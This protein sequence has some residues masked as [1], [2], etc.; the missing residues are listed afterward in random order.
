MTWLL[1]GKPL[2]SVLVSRQRY[3]GD[4]VMAT[5]V[6]EALR[7]GD[8][9]L[10]LGFLCETG[11]GAV[12]AG[13]DLLDD[14]HLLGRKR[15]GADARARGMVE[16]LSLAR[17]NDVESPRIH[18]ASGT[19]DLIKQLKTA[20]YDL[21]VDLFFN[22]FSAWLFKLAGIPF[23][24]GGTPKWRRRL[25]TH[26]VVRTDA[27]WSHPGLS[28][29]APG[30]LGEHLCRL[31][32]LVHAET[33]LPFLDWL[34]KELS[35]RRIMPRLSPR[36]PEESVTRALESIGVGPGEDFL[37]LAPGATWPSKEWPLDSWRDLVQRLL[38]QTALPLVFLLPPTRAAR[39]G[40]MSGEIPAGRGGVLPLLGLSEAL[41]VIDR[42]TALVTVDGGV[43]HA[44]VGLGRPTLGLF[45]PTDPEIWFPYTGAG[46]Y[47]VLAEAPRCHPCDLHECNEFI[48]LPRLTAASVVEKIRS[49]IRDSEPRLRGWDLES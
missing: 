46:P 15:K 35:G 32:P 31:A 1:E 48:C 22:P 16:P 36:V 23:R 24:I 40:L 43:L 20:R 8:P 38:P 34:D 27:K 37:L 6:L 41:D 45:G 33:S 2:R 13:H 28:R 42:C 30:G 29:V 7:R 49:L 3:L 11:H 26:T 5:V 9:N 12:L 44:A 21:A 18:P 10:R 47:R 17:L 4:I 25:Y 19:L 39:W 14:L